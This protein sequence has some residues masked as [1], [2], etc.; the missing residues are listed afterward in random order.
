MLDIYN[1]KIDSFMGT[2]LSRD[3]NGIMVNNIKSQETVALGG[4][5]VED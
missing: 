4:V 1:K 5:L 2:K 3:N